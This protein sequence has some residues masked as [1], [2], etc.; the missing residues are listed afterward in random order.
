MSKW[1]CGIGV[2]LLLVMAAF[3]GMGLVYVSGLMD[4]SEAPQF[5]K[6]IFPVLFVH[7]TIHLV[8]LAAFGVAALALP[9][10]RRAL[11]FI[12]AGAVVFSGALAVYLGAVV[13]SVILFGVAGC[14][15][16]AGLTRR[17]ADS[18]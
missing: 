5:L 15:L 8:A 17:P 10:A 7:V 14:F 3:H 12:I 18:L 6:D 11:S 13:P 9:A 2:G 4:E 1:L 16:G